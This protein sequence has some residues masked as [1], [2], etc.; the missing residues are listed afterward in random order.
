MV[1]EVKNA[2]RMVPRVVEFN[3]LL[4][5]ALELAMLVAYLFCLGDLDEVVE[6]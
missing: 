1:E 5:G 4:N 3:V 6:Q 2:T